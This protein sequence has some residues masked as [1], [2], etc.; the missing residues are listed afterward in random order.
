MKICH[1]LTSSSYAGIEQHVAELAYIQDINHE[2]TI[3]CNKQIAGNYKEFNVIEI[4]NFSRRSLFGIFKIYQ[5]LNAS[6]FDIVH[7]H[8]SKPVSILRI[9][10]YFLEFNF[11]AL[12]MALR[13]MSVSLIMLIL[14]LEAV[15][16]L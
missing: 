2:V 15:R 1:F 8:A 13:K 7:A 4:S 10:K 6:K 14:L 12:F 16:V 3:L 9:V 5:I 11:I